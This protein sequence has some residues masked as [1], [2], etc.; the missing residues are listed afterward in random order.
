MLNI[1]KYS[2]RI[3]NQM[4]EEG[5]D[6]LSAMY[7]VI[8]RVSDINVY[9]D[10]ALFE[11]LLTEEDKNDIL[12]KEEKEYLSNIIKPFRKKITRVEKKNF[13]VNKIN[14]KEDFVEGEIQITYINNVSEEL[15]IIPFFNDTMFK[16]MEECKGYTLQ[17]LEL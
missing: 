16:K 10:D 3:W 6:L 14:H 5:D 12:N 8:G 7:D 4:E 13:Y 17:E 1:E 2:K 9:D 15:A 11:W